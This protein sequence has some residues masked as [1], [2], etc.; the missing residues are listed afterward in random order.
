MVNN[1]KHLNYDMRKCSLVI[2][3]N[4]PAVVDTKD[5]GDS[6][7]SGLEDVKGSTRHTATSVIAGKRSSTSYHEGILQTA[8]SHQAVTRCS[9]YLIF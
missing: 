4:I 1:Y 9:C 5:L 2:N 3:T 6:N 7:N 8:T